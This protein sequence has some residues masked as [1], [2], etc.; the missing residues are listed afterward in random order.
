MNIAFF[1][2]TYLPNRDGVVTCLLNLKEQYE[3]EGHKVFVFTSGT[4][5]DKKNN[6]DPSVY[7]HSSLKFP[8]Y[9]DYKVA[10]LPFFSVSKLRENKIDIIHSHAL[11]TMGVAA[12]VGAKKMKIPCVETFHTKVSQGTH[13]LTNNEKL[14]KMGE[15]VV[16]KYLRWFSSQFDTVTCPSENTKEMLS[17]NGIKAEVYPNSVDIHRF[18]PMSMASEERRK[19]FLLKQKEY[20]EKYKI[21][22]NTMI[23]VSRI[24]KEKNI[25]LAIKSMPHILKQ[26]EDA[27]LIIGGRGPDEENLKKLVKELG[28]EKSVIFTGFIPSEDLPMLYSTVSAFAFPSGMFE[29]HGLVALEALACGLPVVGIKNSAVAEMINEKTGETANSDPENFAE[30]C[31]KLLKNVDQYTETRKFAEK[32]SNEK[33]SKRFLDMYARLIEAKT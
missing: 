5:E 15:D 24:V 32:F 30:A 7:Y 8:P 18:I 16:W 33:I 17:V 2:D 1:T 9:P 20:V 13:Y 29:T 26:I 25:D 19:I 28:V 3:K 21:N 12:F 6:K 10:V 11:A 31:I 22:K 27:R 14:Q 4:K 23:F